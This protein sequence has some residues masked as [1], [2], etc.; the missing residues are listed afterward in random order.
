[1]VGAKNAPMASKGGVRGGA[2]PSREIIYEVGPAS[3]RTPGRPRPAPAGR[4]EEEKGVQGGL[5]NKVREVAPE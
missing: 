4:S 3:R 5:K 1:V 2:R